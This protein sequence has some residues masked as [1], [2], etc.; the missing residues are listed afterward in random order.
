MVAGGASIPAAL[1]LAME[2]DVDLKEAP[3]VAGG[4]SI[5][6]FDVDMSKPTIP[7][8]LFLVP[9]LRL[10][11]VVPAASEGRVLLSGTELL[12]SL[13]PFVDDCFV[14]AMMDVM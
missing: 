7:G 2:S 14:E 11:R 8:V 12:P 10:V 13:E 3:A 1:P 5:V 9:L 6:E 4:A